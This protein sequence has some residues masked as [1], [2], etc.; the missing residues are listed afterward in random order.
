MTATAAD[1]FPAISR[2]DWRFFRAG[3]FDQVLLDRGSDLL[4]LAELDQKLW[5]ALSCPVKGLEMDERT[6]AL[7]DSDQDGHIRAPEL[8][9]AIRWAAARLQQADLLIQGLDPLPL[10]AIDCSTPAG[11]ALHASARQIL[12]SL[13]KGESG[14]I[15]VA[16][17]SNRAAILAAMPLNGDGIITARSSDD[18]AIRQAITLLARTWEGVAD[19]SGEAGIDAALIET[20]F[21]AL[22]AR[23]AWE[24]AAVLPE[25]LADAAAASAA[26]AALAAV[27]VKVDDYFTRCA[28]AAF[29]ERAGRLLN[30]SEAT[31]EALSPQALHADSEAIAALPLARIAPDA[32][33]PLRG[34]LNPAWQSAIAVLEQAAVRPL[35]GETGQLVAADW[36]RLCAWLAPYGAWQ[37]ARP[38]TPLDELDAADRQSL[39]VPGLREILLDRVAADAAVHED[40][41]SVV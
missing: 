41:K 8:M 3:G 4:Q 37:A 35:L 30:G 24:A 16:D 13:G 39:A 9:A 26:W 19:S 23:Q 11:E 1:S 40:R 10:S 28:L 31:L 18:P 6:L 7:I 34:G 27:R 14:Q 32:A 36:Q 17:A 2:H 25:G 22:A 12:D 29:D 38:Q 33:L 21:A 20:A 5:A 15:S